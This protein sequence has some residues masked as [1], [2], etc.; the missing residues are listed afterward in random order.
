MLYS[1]GLP[2][3][4]G[5]RQA[6]VTRGGGFPAGRRAPALAAAAYVPACPVLRAGGAC[7]DAYGR[8]RSVTCWRVLSGM[9][10][11]RAQGKASAARGIYHDACACE[12][13]DSN[14]PYRNLRLQ[15]AA[16]RRAARGS[17]RQ[18]RRASCGDVLHGG[19]AAWG[20]VQDF[21]DADREMAASGGAPPGF[22]SGHGPGPGPSHAA[23][24]CGRC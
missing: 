5:P 1:P 17:P 12:S 20:D 16:C 8:A 13:L 2:A 24:A 9:Q 11:R 10:P 18:T 23:G 3:V 21:E 22:E 6:C 14:Y 15:H 4:P 19:H 7:R